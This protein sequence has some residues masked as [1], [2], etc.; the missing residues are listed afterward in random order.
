MRTLLTW[1]SHCLSVMEASLNGLKKSC[2]HHGLV[3]AARFSGLCFVLDSFSAAS[4]VTL[5]GL[6]LFIL[7]AFL[8]PFFTFLA[9]RIEAG[10]L[11]PPFSTQLR[12]IPREK[13]LLL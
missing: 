3:L 8:G 1:R 6:V 13:T 4:H 12:S 11:N 10:L 2:W 5:L 7:L 9:P